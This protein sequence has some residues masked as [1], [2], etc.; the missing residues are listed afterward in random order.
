MNEQPLDGRLICLGVTGSIAAYKSAELAR[1]FIAAGAEVQALM[2]RSAAA[3]LGPLTLETL[4]RRRVMNDPLAL[5]PDQ[6]IEHIV[7]ADTAD[8]IVVAPA[9]ARWIAAMA[10]GL[11]DDVVTAT[12]LA[13]AAPVVV[14]PAM[15]GEMYGH[16]ATRANV[17]TIRDWGYTVVEPEDGALA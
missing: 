14:A 5:L 12:C 16:P 9:T 8:V 10:H 15:D 17:A 3:F 11:S 6:R 13:T 2:T 4:T 7:A 1:A